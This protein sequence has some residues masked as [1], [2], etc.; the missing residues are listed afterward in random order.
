MR[1]YKRSIARH[2]MKKAGL[3]HVNRRPWGYRPGSPVPV[4]L[5]S[6]FSEHW[7]DFV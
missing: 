5:P 6:Y 7:R 3:Q 4:R 2:N 1:K